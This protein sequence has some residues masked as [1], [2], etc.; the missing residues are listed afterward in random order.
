MQ[1]IHAIINVN[2]DEGETVCREL[3]A[4]AAGLGDS[5]LTGDYCM[6]NRLMQYAI[7]EWTCTDTSVGLYAV[8]LDKEPIAAFYK[9]YRKDRGQWRFISQQCYDK[10]RQF[11]LQWLDNASNNFVMIGGAEEEIGDTYQ[12][13]YAEQLQH[14]KQVIY[15]G[16]PAD[17]VKCLSGF[18]HTG[19]MVRIR[20]SGRVL[21]VDVKHLHVPFRV[22]SK[23]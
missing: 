4:Q 23:R 15:K 11:M 14:V 7:S 2:R 21:D 5:C 8:Y 10:F 17:V 19:T 20:Q 9:G 1:L 12:V 16:Q 18:L 6:D 22:D 13:V 3:A